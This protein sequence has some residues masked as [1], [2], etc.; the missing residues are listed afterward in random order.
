MCNRGAAEVR[1]GPMRNR[2]IAESLRHLV[3]P[4]PSVSRQVTMNVRSQQASVETVC[5]LV[6]C[7]L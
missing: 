2:F 4:Y 6:L 7:L 5:L 1:V 3:A